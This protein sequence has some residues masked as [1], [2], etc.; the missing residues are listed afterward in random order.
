VVSYIESRFK[1]EKYN[2]TSQIPVKKNKTPQIKINSNPNK[3]IPTGH[4]KLRIHHQI[5]NN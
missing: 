5:H 2:K 1:K 4:N 3:F